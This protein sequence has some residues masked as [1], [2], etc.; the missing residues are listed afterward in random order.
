MASNRRRLA[1]MSLKRKDTIG[2]MLMGDAN[3]G[4]TSLINRWLDK[5]FNKE[6]QPTVEHYRTKHCRE[7]GFTFGI[8]DIAGSHQFP[9]MEDLYIKKSDT[10]LLVY[11]VG[12][13]KSR[14]A[15]EIYYRKIDK[16]IKDRHVTITIVGTKIDKSTSHDNSDIVAISEN[17]EGRYK[18][19]LTSAKDDIGVAEV[20]KHATESVTNQLLPTAQ[21]IQ[22]LTT[23]KDS[24]PDKR[25][26]CCT[27]I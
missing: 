22:L 17:C 14:K 5:S 26:D 27:I 9:A 21:R 2:V 25:K 3:V 8:V 19:F 13:P 4:K 16:A 23:Q 11:E 12:D 20:F 15:L 7:T 18:H 1:M 24:K 10:I 6:Y